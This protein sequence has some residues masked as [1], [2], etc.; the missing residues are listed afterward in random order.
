MSTTLHSFIDIFETVFV[1]GEE[2]VQLKKTK[3][4]KSIA[5]SLPENEKVVLLGKLNELEKRRRNNK[6]L[7]YNTYT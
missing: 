1:N 3:L 2:K 6:I 4:M 7:Y 5:K